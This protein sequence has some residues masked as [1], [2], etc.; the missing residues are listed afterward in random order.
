[1]PAECSDLLPRA[2]HYDVIRRGLVVS[3][4]VAPYLYSEWWCE[5]ETCARLSALIDDLRIE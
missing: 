1:L 4:E 5:I 3:F 2:L